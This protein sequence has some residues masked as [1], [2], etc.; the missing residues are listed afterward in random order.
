MKWG[1]ERSAAITKMSGIPGCGKFIDRQYDRYLRLKFEFNWRWNRNPASHRSF[2]KTAPHLDPLQQRLLTELNDSGVVVCRFS[3]LLND[4]ELWT[5]LSNDVTAFISSQQIQG[6]IA[7]AQQAFNEKKDANAVAHYIVSYYDQNTRPLIH[8]GT[9]LVDLALNSRVLD[10]VNSYLGL[11]SRL[12][13]FDMWHTLPLDTDTRILSQRWHRDPEDRKKIR[14]FLYFNDVDEQ[15]GAME[16]FAGSQLGGPYQDLF[17]W[18]DPLRTP[19]PPEDDL[20]HNIPSS[21]RILLS[22]PPGTLIFCDTAGFH[23]GGIAKAKSRIVATAAYVTPASLHHRRY[24]L[25]PDLRNAPMTPQVRF[26]LDN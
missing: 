25:A 24:E 16:Y 21:K 20:A 1:I 13:Y 3:E 22:G 6:S 8:S 12:I 14:I 4:S 7:K 15:A 10:V 19:Y 18:R 5:R 9:P 23:R 11:W 17:P 2:V 26:A